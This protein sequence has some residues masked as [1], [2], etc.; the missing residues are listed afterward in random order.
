MSTLRNAFWAFALFV[1]AMYAFF[2]ALGAWD[3]GE[4]LPVT[5]AMVALAV[6]WVAHAW[7]A[8]RARREQDPRLARAR[9]RR[10]F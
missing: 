5:I 3:P 8:S 10:G 9:E 1:L 2:V 4:V 6:L 7:L